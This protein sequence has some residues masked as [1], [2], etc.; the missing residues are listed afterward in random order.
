VPWAQNAA[1]RKMNVLFIAVDDLRP[2]LGCYDAPVVQSPNIDKLAARGIVFTRTYC[3]YAI[4]AGSRNSLLT[5]RRPDT[6]GIWNLST[7]FRT[8]LP[9]VVT[10][11]QQFKKNGYH[12]EGM[13]KIFHTSNCNHD[14]E[15]S[16][17]VALWPATERGALREK[18]RQEC[19]AKK[20][21]LPQPPTG[22]PSATKQLFDI[23]LTNHT[24]KRLSALKVD[25][26]KPFFLAV[27]FL[28]PHLPF[29]A[30][31]RY[32]NLYDPTQFKLE[33]RKDLPTYTPPYAA[34]NAAELQSY[35]GVPQKG[36]IPDQLAR[37][38]IHGYYACI[39]YI[40][41]QI[42]RILDKLNQ[43]GLR[44]STIVILWGD[45]GWHLGD[46]GMWSKL[47]TYE[48][49]T[50]STLIISAPGMRAVG[51]KCNALTEFVD[52]YPSLCELAGLPKTN[53]LEGTSFVPLMNNPKRAWKKAA[54]S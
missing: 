29:I 35:A 15:Q 6:I 44:E 53:G 45:H 2:T 38:L 54:F 13:G 24:M 34:N 21:R 50:H 23:K 32:W 52:I 42:G 14:D 8:K 22:A 3:Q 47:T 31:K 46:H 33:D 39:S 11:P 10:L 49:A 17:S 28:K 5:G 16:W 12:V 19:F 1:K 18:A 7:N 30:P 40:D 48:R 4:C 41:A 51:Q 36:P 9:D 37:H 25:G 43:L 26:N 20:P 27:G